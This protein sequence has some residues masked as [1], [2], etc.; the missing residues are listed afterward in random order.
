MTVKQINEDNIRDL[1]QPEYILIVHPVLGVID[2]EMGKVAC[3][4]IGKDDEISVEMLC[5][6]A[7]HVRRHYVR[8]DILAEYCEDEDRDLDVIV[9]KDFL[10]DKATTISG[11][12]GEVLLSDILQFKEGYE[13][14][15][16]KQVHRA[17]RNMS[18]PGV[19]VLAYRISDSI[20]YDPNDELVTV[21]VKTRATYEKDVLSKA[22]MAAG[23]DVQKD[24]A[25][26]AM[27]LEMYKK[28]SS[29][30]RDKRAKK[31]VD[32]FMKKSEK[33]YKHVLAMAVVVG[34]EDL[35]A[36]NSKLQIARNSQIYDDEKRKIL[37]FETVD[38]VYVVHKGELMKLIHSIYDGGVS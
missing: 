5:D 10:P 8:D 26:I 1:P 18:D 15:R 36:E 16:Y 27:T 37:R 28:R 32:R 24:H 7:L 35:R 13:V 11:D 20:P 2:D 33:P 6:W 17:N 25:R 30:A 29:H 38:R 21:E 4:T 23:T 3:Y 31:E 19:D 14:P 12:F 9:R 34:A 22:L